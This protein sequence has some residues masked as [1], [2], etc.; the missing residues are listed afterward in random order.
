MYSF[1][2]ETS[3]FGREREEGDPEDID[4]HMSIDDF[5]TIGT[6]LMKTLS[7]FDNQEFVYN[8]EIESL[9]FKYLIFNICLDQINRVL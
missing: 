1:T 4:L 5:K 2:Q 9:T 7:Y 3:F 6:D 8:L